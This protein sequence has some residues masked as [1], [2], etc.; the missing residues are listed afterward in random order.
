MRTLRGIGMMHPVHDSISARA[1]VGGAHSDV[2]KNVEESFPEFIHLK[3]PV[4]SI[5]VK[6][7]GLREHGEIPVC[8]EKIENRH[9]DS[10]NLIEQ[11]RMPFVPNE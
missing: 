7:K 10:L 9:K 11:R 2:S 8:Y 3:S 6:Q 4:H 1:E 5:L